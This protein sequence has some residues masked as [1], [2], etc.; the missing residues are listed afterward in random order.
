MTR[1]GPNF[2]FS[3]LEVRK[4]MSSVDSKALRKPAENY[5]NPFNRGMGLIKLNRY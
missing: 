3:V 2:G 5:P 1:D 4:T